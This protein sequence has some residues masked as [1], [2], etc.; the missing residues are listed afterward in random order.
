MKNIY[1]LLFSIT[2]FLGFSQT[3]KIQS[4]KVGKGISKSIGTQ[5][6]NSS[7]NT[8]QRDTTQ[9]KAKRVSGYDT[10]P[11]IDK[12][13]YKDLYNTVRAIDTTLTINNHY[14]HNYLQKDLFGLLPFAN[15]GMSYNVLDYSQ[16]NPS[17]LPTI[18]FQA[19][20]FSLLSVDDIFYYNVPTPVSKIFYRSGIKQGQN[21]DAFLA[22]NLSKQTNVFVGYRGLR[23]LGAYI[24]ELSS[25][26]NFKIGGSYDSKNLRYQLKTHIVFQDITQKENGGIL[27][28]DLFEDK[29]GNRERLDVRLRDAQSLFKNTRLFLDHS[30]QINASKEHKVWLKHQI[31]YNYFSNLYTQPT[32]VSPNIQSSYFGEFFSNSVRDKLRNNVL[33]N[34]VDV[35]FD[36]KKLGQLS[37]FASLYQNDYYF[38]SIVN[39]S[40]GTVIPNQIKENILNIGGSYVL[41]TKSL[42]VLLYGTQSLS[43]NGY[44]NFQAQTNVNITEKIGLD[45]FYQYASKMPN[46]T[47]RLFQSDFVHYNWYNEFSNE[48]FHEVTAG[49]E[50]PYANISGTYKL[51]TDKMYFSND[52][53][54]TDAFGISKQ[55]LLSPKQFSGTIN[56]LGI[57]AQ[58]EFNWR[59]WSLDNTLEFQQVVQDQDILNVPS[60]I[61]RN[62]LYYSDFLFRKALYIQGGVSAQYFTKYYMNGYNAL[63]GDYYVQN[64]TKIGNYPMIDVFLNMKIQTARIYIAVEQL[65][66]LIGKS[67]HFSAPSYPYRDLTFRIG[68]TWN[69]FN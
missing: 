18:G 43:D 37:A 12:Y 49:V 68:L 61:T 9:L 45:L 35:S 22:T 29:D 24:N 56:Y 39:S 4:D 51:I 3:R 69:F 44:T 64:Q 55:L 28:L 34:K 20:Q 7:V 40:D 15:D 30:Y 5:V 8:I 48:K 25:I 33:N 31:E 23:S 27:E 16:L 66:H 14:R 57:K 46:M 60:F 52:S 17:L 38:N 67:H 19:R 11:T 47:S 36:S 54:E 41:K 1:V 50:T 26:G 32:A 10:I 13:L 63:L 59:K 2:S 21:L 62:T 42:D 58:K 65:N 53:N 6:N